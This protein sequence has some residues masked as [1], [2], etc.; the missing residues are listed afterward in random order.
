MKVLII[1]HNPMTTYDCMGR[2]LLT[3]FSE[4]NRSELCQL[5]IYPTVPNADKCD[6]FYRITDNSLF[7]L[8]QGKGARGCL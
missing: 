5:Y 1:S 8:L 7:Y 3:L 2:T 4:F 6:S